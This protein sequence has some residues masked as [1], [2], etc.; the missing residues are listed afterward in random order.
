MLHLTLITIQNLLSIIN[1][2]SNK[3]VCTFLL[4][5]SKEL[6]YLTQV[7][8]CNISIVEVKKYKLLHNIISLKRKNIN[9][10]LFSIKMQNER[11]SQRS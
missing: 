6:K 8:M 1:N 2:V 11:I 7:P 10:Y 5:S 3:N 4:F 9:I